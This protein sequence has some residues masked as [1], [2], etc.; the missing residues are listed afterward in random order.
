VEEILNRV[1]YNKELIFSKSKWADLLKFYFILTYGK[2][3]IPVLSKEV[4]YINRYYWLKLFY[5]HYSVEFGKDAGIEQEIGLLLEEISNNLENFDWNIL[6][7]I[8]HDIKNTEQ[9]TFRLD[10]KNILLNWSDLTSILDALQTASGQTYGKKKLKELTD[11]LDDNQTIEIDKNGI[12]IEI[13]NKLE[14]QNLI[15]TYDSN[16]QLSQIL[17]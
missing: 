14:L 9:E 17:K 12:K 1:M 3:K 10:K 7:K 16:I 13:K 6:E 8:S 15:N 11:K 5:H 2:D 4:L